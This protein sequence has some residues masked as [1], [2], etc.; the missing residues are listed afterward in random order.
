MANTLNPVSSGKFQ[1]FVRDIIQAEREPIRQ[2]EARKANENERLKLLQ[3]FLG[4]VRK[5]PEIYKELESFRKFRELKPEWPAKDQMDVFVDKETA[6][7]GEYQI[8][9]VQLA[10][11]RSMISNGYESP[12]DE[13]GIG[14]FSYDTPSG[15]VTSI[16]IGPGDNTLRGLVNAINRERHSGVTA[17]LIN[18]GWG[19]DTPWRA[20][21]STKKSGID[22]DAE[23]PEFYFLDGDFRFYEDEGRA[24]QNAII[25]FNGFEIM[26]QTNRFELLPG[27]VLDLKQAKEDYEFTL[28]ITEDIAKI[29]AK[30]KALVE[31]INAVLDFIGKQNKL[32][33]HTP[34]IRTLGGDT[35]LFT[36]E[37]RVRSWI[38]EAFNVDPDDDEIFMRL[39]EVGINFEKTGLLNFN[40]DKFKKAVSANFDYVGSL[41]AGADNFIAQLKSMTDGFLLP[42]VGV[43][44]AREKGI[45]DRIK[46][47]DEDITRK[48]ANLVRREESLR[49][50]FA[51]LE[52]FIN[53]MQG[54]QQFFAQ[55][56]GGSTVIPGVG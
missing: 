51:Q 22:N 55:S 21:I 26:A 17:A 27:V 53:Q 32:D 8:E 12:D 13:I 25:K 18:D 45:R 56:L 31:A 30:V 52:G 49:R 47:I 34:T 42:E 3:E 43:V 35:S 4:K 1:K 38:F 36:V 50:K 37:S 48:E 33:A 54:Q 46:T 19:E 39:S 24:A 29:A 7:P 14:Y 2:M 10:G 41:F 40:E 15:D 6:E 9:V 5:L 16:F 44:V 20:V 11:K 28:T 23:F